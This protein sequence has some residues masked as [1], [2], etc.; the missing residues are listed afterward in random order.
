MKFEKYDYGR[1]NEQCVAIRQLTS[2]REHLT[3]NLNL[4]SGANLE[5]WSDKRQHDESCDIH[6]GCS[7]FDSIKHSMLKNVTMPGTYSR[8][9]QSRRALNE[10]PAE[11][12]TS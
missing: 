7:T 9:S 10:S 4:T 1:L 5:G 11:F 2:T 8:T 6:M 3:S 12:F